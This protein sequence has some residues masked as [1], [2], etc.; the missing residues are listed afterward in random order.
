MAMGKH[1]PVLQ[2]VGYKGSGK[3]TLM[4]K[5]IHTASQKGLRVASI[6]HHGH[7]GPP[8]PFHTDSDRHA[9]AGS[10]IAAVEGNGVLQLQAKQTENWNL[11][12]LIDFYQFFQP[13]IIFVEGYKHTNYPKVVLLRTEEDKTLFQICET[14][15]CSISENNAEAAAQNV[16]HFSKAQEP[17]YL[18]YLLKKVG[19]YYELF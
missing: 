10:V 2:I 11:V 9:H 13:D 18:A 3:T 8:E 1:C 6:K 19:E 16:P 15:I 17:E 4:E 12:D 7:G 14:I 5:L